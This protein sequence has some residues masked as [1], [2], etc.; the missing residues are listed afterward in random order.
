MTGFETIFENVMLAPRVLMPMIVAKSFSKY[1]A[2]R[3]PEL[4]VGAMVDA[5]AGDWGGLLKSACRRLVLP[6][7]IGLMPVNDDADA[8]V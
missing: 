4:G 8:I 2:N 3:S 6:R 7:D 5:A 1:D